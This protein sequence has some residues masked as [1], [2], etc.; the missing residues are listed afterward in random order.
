MLLA[1]TLK[2]GDMSQRMPVVSGWVASEG[3]SV[4][5]CQLWCMTSRKTQAL[6]GLWMVTEQFKRK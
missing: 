6:S 4:A 1:L 5:C 2:E 3:D